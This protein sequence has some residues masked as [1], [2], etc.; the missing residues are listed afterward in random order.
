MDVVDLVG[1]VD[2][3]EVVDASRPGLLLT[4]VLQTASRLFTPRDEKTWS[5]LDHAPG[6]G[7]G[8]AFRRGV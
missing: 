8:R 1:L 4:M 6:H 3:V 7:L 2:I 5:D